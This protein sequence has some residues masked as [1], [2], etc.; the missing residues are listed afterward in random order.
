MA[1]LVKQLQH[2]QEGLSSDPHHLC[3]G[4]YVVIPAP[5][6][7]RQADAW[8]TLANQSSQINELKLQRKT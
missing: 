2:K 7:Q 5:G 1:R 6:S 3:E 8:G 4:G